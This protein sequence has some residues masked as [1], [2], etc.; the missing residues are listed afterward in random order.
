MEPVAY[1]LQQYQK[2]NE[3]KIS[4]ALAAAAEVEMA[5]SHLSETFFAVVSLLHIADRVNI[6]SARLA[7]VRAAPFVLSSSSPNQQAS[8][9]NPQT[10]SSP[11]SSVGSGGSLLR[12][13]HAMLTALAAFDT[14][15]AWEII[16]GIRFLDD[17]A[18]AAQG[19]S[20]LN[21][22]LRDAQ[23]AILLQHWSAADVLNGRG[24]EA[25]VLFGTAAAAAAAA[26]DSGDSVG[27]RAVKSLQPTVP[28]DMME[29]LLRMR[30][31]KQR[32][33]GGGWS[34]AEK[35][36]RLSSVA[37]IMSAAATQSETQRKPTSAGRP[38]SLGFY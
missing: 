28:E 26:D 17:H 5:Q 27:K 8:R 13:L 7:L 33:D 34:T 6:A 10:S 31:A 30:E 32:G 4:L 11:S 15:K 25:Q 14:A 36:A 19:R 9:P 37:S 24:R 3:K 16:S 2:S 23:K 20:S 12:Q 21:D 18:A 38:S 1:V 29:E 35:M 22:I